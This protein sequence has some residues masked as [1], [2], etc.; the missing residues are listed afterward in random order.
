MA[1]LS[2]PRF[3]AGLCVVAAFL[4]ACG[5]SDS[6]Q[7]VQ[8]GA[9][10]APVGGHHAD[11]VYRWGAIESATHYQLWVTDHRDDYF[12][13]FV[14]AADAGCEPVD[15]A[16]TPV[17]EFKPTIQIHD[18]ILR[19]QVRAFA[20]D[21]PISEST[22]TAFNTL[23][24][25]TVQPYTDLD[26][27]GAPPNPGQGWPTIAFA[28]YVVLNND[29]NATAVDS[30]QWQQSVS[31]QRALDGNYRVGWRYDW[32]DAQSGDPLAVKSYPQI[33]YGS[34]LGAHVSGTAE[35]LG[36]PVRVADMEQFRIRYAYEET[37]TAERNL[38]F[39]SFFHSDCTITGPNFD[40]DNRRFEMMV[41]IASPSIRTPGNVRAASGV[42]I[43][44]QLWDIWI[45]PAQDRA[46]LAYT[47][48]NELTAATLNWNAFVDHTVQWTAAN[49]A[50][51]GVATLDTDWCLSAIEFGTET[52]WGSGAL[53]LS[54]F[55]VSRQA[56]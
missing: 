29:W 13:E 14:S 23:R 4:A 51:T 54:E 28:D 50:T 18:S 30:D 43:D 21:E 26:T 40:V 32:L 52:W 3:V 31:V 1:P 10:L 46:Y 12:S 34:K 49:A 15:Q 22:E 5:G 7:S 56:E 35:A 27:I 9:A 33:V 53:E 42:L 55:S 19:W 11:P 2:T 37:G 6:Q 20:D 41:W 47:A 45:K 39:E 16:S 24:S 36:V 48:Q 17:C 8:P 25:L 38:A 44:N